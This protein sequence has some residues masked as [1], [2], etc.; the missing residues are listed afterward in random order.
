LPLKPLVMRLGESGHRLHLLA[1]GACDHLLVPVEDATE[2]V[3]SEHIDLEH[4]VEQLEPLLFL[5][6]RAL[7][8]LTLRA[9]ERA[10]AI[11]SVEIRLALADEQHS[12]YR[13][14]VR[15]ALPERDHRTLLKLIQLDLE[16]HLPQ[17]AITALTVYAQPDRPRKVQQ[18]LF[19]PQSPEPGRLEVLLARLRKV[20]GEERVGSA[21]L[22]DSR[23]PD[24]F[25]MTAFSS[26]TA[27]VK[28]HSTTRPQNASSATAFH[29]S[30]VSAL[31]RV[32]PP[33]AVHVRMSGA[34]PAALILDGEKLAIETR[35]G[36]WRTS[37]AW[38]SN[39]EWCREEW[40]V[41]LQDTQQRC[42][43]LAYDPGANC[44]YLIGIYD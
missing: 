12:E 33:L 8:K 28:L 27:P 6:S 15:P 3:L 30:R 41:A 16:S 37:G 7:E 29:G 36:P 1:C 43:R 11:A 20:A 31:R 18:G 42:F 40:D 44:W 10:L 39:A 4:P 25:H 34:F 14:T 23:A 24:A 5:V 35:S 13:R 19:A 9:Q 26:G 32:R 2:T 38:W 17:A 21:E 22:L